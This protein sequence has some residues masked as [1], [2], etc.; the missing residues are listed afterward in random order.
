[1]AQRETAKEALQ[2]FDKLKVLQ[3]HYAGKAGGRLFL[4]DVIEGLMGF[5]CTDLQIDIWDYIAYGPQYGMV[6]AQRGQAKTTIT[7]IFA[8]FCLIHKPE[9]RILII[10]AGA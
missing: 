1:M 4:K 5:V 9:W 8:V 10:S 7:A 3:D 6:Q 2:R